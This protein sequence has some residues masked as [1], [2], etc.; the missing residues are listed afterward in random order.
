MTMRISQTART[1]ARRVLRRLAGARGDAGL[2]ALHGQP[3]WP[4]SAWSGVVVAVSP[5]A[6]VAAEHAAQ[7]GLA[8]AAAHRRYD[9]GKWSGQTWEERL[10]ERDRREAT[11]PAALPVGP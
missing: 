4:R 1:I 8:Y 9:R 10:V 5:E 2:R 7:L 6:H 3:D 11:T